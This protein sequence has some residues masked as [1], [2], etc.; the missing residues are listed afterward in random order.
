MCDTKKLNKIGFFDEDFFLYWE[1]IFLERKI[2]L[3][4]YKMAMALNAFVK[5]DSS[6]SSENTY[7]T[8]FVRFSNF[9][10]GELVYDFKLEKLR[11]IKIFRKLM[12]NI[13]LFI[14]NIL[15]FQLKGSLRNIAY[16]IGILKFTIFYMNKIK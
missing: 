16:I 1:D 12:Q 13:I 9:L 10:Y 8:D 3:T 5:H 14:F 6:N 11:F 15:F 4:K 7:K 2:N